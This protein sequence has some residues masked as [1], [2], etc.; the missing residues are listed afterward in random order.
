MKKKSTFYILVIL[1]MLL[2]FSPSFVTLAQQNSVQAGAVAD[3]E[4]DAQQYANLRRWFLMGCL[5]QFQNG[6]TTIRMDASISLPPT[7]LL[8]KSPEYIRSYA[9]AYSA[10]VKKYRTNSLWVGRAFGISC[11]GGL[12]LV[13]LNGLLDPLSF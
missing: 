10:K 5:S 2:T 7:R 8:G 9:A 11:M 4:R 13:G 12:V 6:L 3:A 1:T